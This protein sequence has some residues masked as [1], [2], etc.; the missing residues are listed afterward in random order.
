MEFAVARNK[1]FRFRKIHPML[2][3]FVRAIP[4]VIE[5]DHWSP[6][7]E[8]RIF[9]DASDD[10]A[11]ESVR[12]EWKAYVEPD[13]HEYFRSSRET[14]ISDLK[15][16][17]TVG[18]ESALEIPVAHAEAWLN[19]LNQARLALAAG[20][21]FDESILGSAREPDLTTESGIR[22]FQINLYAFMQECLID[23]LD[24]LDEKNGLL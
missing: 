15:Q 8:A 12:A 2:A 4:S 16:M 11:L 14:V 6:D 20:F 21:D 5:P 7:A 1:N 23:R 13:L 19:A 9:P 22:L 10:P 17:K 18:E 24:R 3:E